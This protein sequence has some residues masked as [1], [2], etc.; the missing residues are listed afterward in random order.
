MTDT[1]YILPARIECSLKTLKEIGLHK[2]P[3]GY[4]FAEVDP[5][6]CWYAHLFYLDHKKCMLFINA[7]TRYPVIALAISR[8]EIFHL[9]YL[10]GETLRTQLAYKNVPQEIIMKFLEH[11][12]RPELCKS[13]N[14]SI[15]GT[16]VDY[17]YHIKAHLD[18]ASEERI[19]KSQEQLSSIISKIPCSI[20]KYDDPSTAFRNE[21]E[22]RYGQTGIVGEKSEDSNLH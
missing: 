13:K 1:N 22:K 21:L 3:V 19:A 12:Y 20:L 5:F 2:E 4:G 15:I 8:K 10:L 11:L 16:A 9:N 18:H 14:R 7:L 17:E 6:F